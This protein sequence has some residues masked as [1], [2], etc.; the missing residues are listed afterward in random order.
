MEELMERSEVLVDVVTPPEIVLSEAQRAAQA[1]TEVIKSKAK[2][3]MIRGEQYLEFEDWQTVGRFYGVTPKVVETKYVK[4]G[5]A[6]GFEARAVVVRLKDGLEI[7]AAEAMCLN[8]EANWDNKPLFM[9]KSMAQTR[10]CAKALRNVLAWVVV[11]AGFK[12]TP[13]EEIIELENIAQNAPEKEK[14]SK[15][16]PRYG[17]KPKTQSEGISDAQKGFISRLIEKR[18]WDNESA[19]RVIS[20]IIGKE[21][22]SLDDLSKDDASKAITEIKK[23]PF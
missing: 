23:E 14:A 8:D 15:P 7:S 19:M 11:L 13:A 4:I 5:T 1:L 6:E 17:G 3:V 2:P 22:A 12:P 9:L 10:A 20:G 21:I 18:G 16:I